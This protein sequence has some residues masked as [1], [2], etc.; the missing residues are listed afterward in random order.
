VLGGRQ[1]TQGGERGMRGDHREI[2]MFKYL[3]AQGS[4]GGSP[5]KNGWVRASCQVKA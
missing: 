1:A 2:R 4:G 5:Q 3:D